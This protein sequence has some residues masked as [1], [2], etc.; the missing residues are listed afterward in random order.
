LKITRSDNI[1][2]KVKN[3]TLEFNDEAVKPAKEIVGNVSINYDGRY[4]SISINSQIED[5]SDVFTFTEVEGKKKIT[6]MQDYPS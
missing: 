1:K 4:D 6:H 2:D 5:S 3:I